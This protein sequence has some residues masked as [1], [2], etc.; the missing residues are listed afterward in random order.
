VQ[1]TERKA[2]A[3][4][5]GTPVSDSRRCRA[6]HG[7]LRCS[8]AAPEGGE[9]RGKMERLAV[10]WNGRNAGSGDSGCGGGGAGLRPKIKSASEGSG[11]EQA[12]A[13]D[14]L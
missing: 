6:Y 11:V 2:P 7:R 14:D 12:L 1:S 4:S 9:A 3:S 10:R 13:D 5:A 8:R